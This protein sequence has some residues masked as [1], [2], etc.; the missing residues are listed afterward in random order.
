ML[1]S[2]C[3]IWP[4]AL[5]IGD[6]STQSKARC[7]CKNNSPRRRYTPIK[8]KDWTVHSFLD[9]CRLSFVFSLFNGA[10]T[11]LPPSVLPFWLSG[12]STMQF[13]ETDTIHTIYLPSIVTQTSLSPARTALRTYKRSPSERG[14]KRYGRHV[15]S[16]VYRAEKTRYF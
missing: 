5:L 7:V 3:D 12:C 6:I 10:R 16:V 11:F 1:E 13:V 8:V 2:W 9:V 4:V 14:W 15:V